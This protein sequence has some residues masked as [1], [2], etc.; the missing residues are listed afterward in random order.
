MLGLSYR[1][2]FVIALLSFLTVMVFGCF[3]LMLYGRIQ[4]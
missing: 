2:L 1:Q 4:I 3:L